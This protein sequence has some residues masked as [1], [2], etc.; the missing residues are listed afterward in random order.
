MVG[1]EVAKMVGKKKATS[2]RE[3]EHG[4]EIRSSIRSFSKKNH[5]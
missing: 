2:L 5:E 1:L 4:G 3:T